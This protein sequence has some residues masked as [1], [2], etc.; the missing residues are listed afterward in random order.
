MSGDR[1]SEHAAALT[2]LPDETL[3]IVLDAL[4]VRGM[5][6]VADRISDDGMSDLAADIA[7]E[8]LFGDGDEPAAIFDPDHHADALRALGRSYY[9]DAA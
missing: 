8:L 5:D 4:C 9:G 7:R 2:V 6:F 3:A 1:P